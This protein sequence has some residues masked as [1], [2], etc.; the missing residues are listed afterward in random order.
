[1]HV[2]GIDGAGRHGWV[3]VVAGRDG[4]A[5]ADVALTVTELIERTEQLMGE[6][7]ATVGI[8]IPIGLPPTPARAVDRLAREFVG[9]KR[10]SS[11]FAAP[12]PS[13]IEFDDH[14]EAGTRLSEQ[15]LPGI[16]IQGFRLIPKIREV[17]AVAHDTRV[18]EVF[19]EASFCAL[20]ER[21]ITTSKKSWDGMVERRRLLSRADS[22]IVVPDSL[23]PAGQVPVDDVLDAAAAAWSA[24][25]MATGKGECIGDPTEFDPVTGRPI[26]MWV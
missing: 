8:D 26:G 4:F 24:W 7:L 9:P 23:G 15:G 14:A 18:V 6:P 1:M 12:H 25:R 16:S 13:I 17:A 5:G 10:R 2:L 21:H 22:P 20:A 19:P 3:G 11:V